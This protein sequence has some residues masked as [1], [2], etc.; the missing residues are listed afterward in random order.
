[1]SINII[2]KD[3]IIIAK[4]I[5]LDSFE[6]GLA[7]Y[8]NDNDFIQVGTWNYQTGKELLAHNHNIIERTINRTQEVLFIKKGRILA[9]LFDEE[10]KKIDSLE[11]KAGD[12]LI[13]L[14]GGHGYKI[15]ED[16]TQ[17][18]EIK[19]GPY[20]GTEKDRRRI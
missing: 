11:V 19:N 2:E 10:D 17:V 12:I 7:F 15:L 20:F 14:N 18:L 8:S 1:M 9:E 6:E 13:L 16:D 5:S 4:H 3:G